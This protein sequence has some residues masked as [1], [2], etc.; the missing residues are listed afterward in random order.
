MR[1]TDLFVRL[2][3]YRPSRDRQP[4]ENFL[5]ELVAHLLDVE[6]GIRAEFLAAIRG[7]SDHNGTNSFDQVG[8]QI[9]TQVPTRSRTPELNGLYLDLVLR[10]PDQRELIVESKIDSPL[11]DRQLGNY[12]RYAEEQPGRMVVIIG[13]VP[14]PVVLKYQNHQRLLGQVFWSELAERWAKVA[15]VADRGFIDSTLELM[16][17]RSMGP[18]E[19]FLPEEVD[20]VS[21]QQAFQRKLGRLVDELERRLGQA[22]PLGGIAEVARFPRPDHGGYRGVGWRAPANVRL[23]ETTFWYFVGIGYEPGLGFPSFS[24]N[25]GPEAVT[26][27]GMWPSRGTTEE[28]RDSLLPYCSGLIAKGFDFNYSMNMKGLFVIRRQSLRMSLEGSTILEYLLDSHRRTMEA[29]ELP[30]IYSAFARSSGLTKAEEY[31]RGSSQAES[32]DPA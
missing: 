1:R 6:R 28:L 17:S 9:K 21:L 11:S 16:R 31:S 30:E 14:S 13:N 15:G 23:S 27:V 5:T 18:V 3:N 10:S 22:D 2:A 20:A 19:S 12:L 7:I 26:F 25:G 4:F 29:A 32:A 24:E 8:T